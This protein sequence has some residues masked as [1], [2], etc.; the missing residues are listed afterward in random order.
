[1]QTQEDKKRLA[2][3]LN[4]FVMPGTG[5][6]VLGQRV[7]GLVISLLIVVLL[8]FPIYRYS[9]SAMDAFEKLSVDGNLAASGIMALSDAWAAN[10]KMIFFCLVGV[11]I[12][13]LYGIIDVVCC[14]KS[15]Q[16]N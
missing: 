14:H 3:V 16:K 13:W 15:A 12:V 9:Q 11:V 8:L 6:M 1:M 5:H 7:K 2:I 4:A 10:K